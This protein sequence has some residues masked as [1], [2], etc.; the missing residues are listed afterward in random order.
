MI[1]QFR[2]FLSLQRDKSEVVPGR[3]LLEMTTRVHA[4]HLYA[5]ALVTING[6]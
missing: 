5:D 2:D 1:C 3:V 4:H 6:N